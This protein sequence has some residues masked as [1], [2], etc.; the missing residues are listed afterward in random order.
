MSEEPEVRS[1]KTGNE[2]PWA[3]SAFCEPRRQASKDS[4]LLSVQRMEDSSLRLIYDCRLPICEV[5]PTVAGH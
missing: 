3:A 2:G 1:Q 5:L 4:K